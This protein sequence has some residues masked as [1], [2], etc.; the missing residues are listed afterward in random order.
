MKT[1]IQKVTPKQ[2]LLY[3]PLL[4]GVGTGGYFGVPALLDLMQKQIDRVDVVIY[5]MCEQDQDCV[6][7]AWKHILEE[8]SLRKAFSG[9]E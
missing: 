1:V 6:N 3:L 4:T 8:K 9:V 2:W 5:L 7:D